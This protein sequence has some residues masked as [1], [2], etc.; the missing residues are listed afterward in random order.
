M[1][2]SI[3]LW[4][5]ADLIAISSPPG[6]FFGRVANFINA[7]LW[8]KP[9]EVSW[10]VVFPGVRAQDCL[11]V[12]GSCARHPSQLYEA[13]LEGLILW[14][15]MLTLVFSFEFLIVVLKEDGIATLFF[16]SIMP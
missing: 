4:S 15:I 8:G 12:V 6:L 1:V 10:G 16:E 14:I 13:V 11:G 2:N 3:S 7:E 5:A 9:T